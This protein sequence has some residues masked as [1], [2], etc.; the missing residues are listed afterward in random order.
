MQPLDAAPRCTQPF[1]LD[2]V[3]GAEDRDVVVFRQLREPPV[4]LPDPPVIDRDEALDPSQRPGHGRGVAPIEHT[5]VKIGVAGVDEPAASGVDR[6]GGVTPRVTGQRQRQDLRWQPG[7]LSN[8]RHAFPGL[9][10]AVVRL[11]DRP[12]RELR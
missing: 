3:V 6:D 12:V 7:E 2:R 11:P 9:A 5:A 1:E 8:G 10:E 4:I